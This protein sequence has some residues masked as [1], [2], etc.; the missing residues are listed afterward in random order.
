M[1]QQQVNE[2][3]L[4]D[5]DDS[6]SSSSSSSSS[7][8][9]DSNNRKPCTDFDIEAWI[10]EEQPKVIEEVRQKE[11]PASPPPG[12]ASS[13]TPQIELMDVDDKASENVDPHFEI[14]RVIA[15]HPTAPLHRWLNL[16]S[17]LCPRCIGVISSS[18][19][20]MG[21]C[22]YCQEPRPDALHDK[23]CPG[24]HVF[25]FLNIQCSC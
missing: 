24:Q 17:I 22:L 2:V 15:H 8:N 19:Y 25:R 9:S 16:S 1:A 11:S 7:S 4:I 5:D 20:P 13:P 3:I 12:S 23:V 10:E 18:H 6:C 21:R 14:F